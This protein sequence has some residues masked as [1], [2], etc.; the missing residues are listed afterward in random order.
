MPNRPEVIA[1]E[2]HFQIPALG[3]LYGP[4]DANNAAGMSMLSRLCEVMP[5]SRNSF[6][7][8]FDGARCQTGHIMLD[9]EGIDHRYGH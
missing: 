8:L 5:T 3:G 2:E 4:V 7:L 9:E 6:R 1:L